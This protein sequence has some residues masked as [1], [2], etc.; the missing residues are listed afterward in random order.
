MLFGLPLVLRESSIIDGEIK[1]TIG[2]F[3][4]LP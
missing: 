4:T 3:V 2:V 1:S